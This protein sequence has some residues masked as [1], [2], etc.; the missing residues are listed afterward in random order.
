MRF[1]WVRWGLLF[2]P[3]QREK[4]KAK[5]ASNS[6]LEW[7]IVFK[8]TTS[9]KCA[10]VIHCKLHAYSARLESLLTPPYSSLLCLKPQF[11]LCVQMCMSTCLC[12]TYLKGIRFIFT[13]KQNVQIIGVTHTQKNTDINK[14]IHTSKVYR[15]TFKK[16]A[17]SLPGWFPWQQA[18]DGR[19]SNKVLMAKWQH[20]DE[21]RLFCHSPR[22]ETCS[23]D[24]DLRVSVELVETGK[25]I[26][27]S[28]FHW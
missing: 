5:S 23:E 22:S 27:L 24:V 18:G 2:Q 3:T 11:H 6:W 20:I 7:Y 14:Q 28:F 8:M 17:W 12:N 13:V 25:N 26:V 21:R 1:V 15:H 9:G 10:T 16:S 19:Y 4:R